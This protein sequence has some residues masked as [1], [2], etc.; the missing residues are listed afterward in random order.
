[1]PGSGNDDF[2]HDP[3][4][5]RST[6]LSFL[7]LWLPEQLL[8]DNETQ[9][10]SVEFTDFLKANRIKQ[11]QSP[12]Y[13]PSSNG[14]AERFVRTVKFSLKANEGDSKSV[15]HHLVDFL[16]NYRSTAHAT[17]NMS[18]NEL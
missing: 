1:M 15:Q 12:P 5:N 4:N 10:N 13:H 7:P 9:F 8:S 2:L 11:V 17:T 16:F 14:L 3:A 6:A 18:P